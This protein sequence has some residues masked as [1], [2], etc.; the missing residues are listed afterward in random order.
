[1]GLVADIIHPRYFNESDVF[2]R[3]PSIS[4]KSSLNH[5]LTLFFVEAE[6]TFLWCFCPGTYLILLFFSGITL[7]IYVISQ[8]DD[9]HSSTIKEW[10]DLPYVKFHSSQQ[11]RGEVTR[12]HLAVNL[13]LFQSFHSS[14]TG[15][16]T[17]TLYK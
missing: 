16:A 13:Y 8:E 6:T 12:L 3:V 10:Y 2:G 1:M 14:Q 7:L 9:F 15:T 4:M 11:R 5:H 17:D